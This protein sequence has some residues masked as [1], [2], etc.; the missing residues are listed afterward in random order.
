MNKIIGAIFIII[1]LF[2]IG[3]GA[4]EEIR[5]IG[6]TF[7]SGG[8][9][10]YHDILYITSGDTITVS[11]ESENVIDVLLNNQL[12]VFKYNGSYYE[13]KESGFYIMFNERELTLYKD[14][15]VIRTLYKK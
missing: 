12:Y 10:N 4:F 15:E 3:I 6:K 14:G 13:E 1:G 11:S 5:S 9:S 7:I 2:L 8:Q